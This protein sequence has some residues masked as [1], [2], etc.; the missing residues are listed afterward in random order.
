MEALVTKPSI[1]PGEGKVKRQ[2][3]WE[4]RLGLLA[5]G[6]AGDQSKV[7]TGLASDSPASNPGSAPGLLVGCYRMVLAETSKEHVDIPVRQTN[8]Y[9][10]IVW[11]KFQRNCWGMRRNVFSL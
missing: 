9:I 5:L 1:T 4:E 3:D 8:D 10:E 7:E 2:L 11:E 6:Q